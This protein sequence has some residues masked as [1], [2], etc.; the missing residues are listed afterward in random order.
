MPIRRRHPILLAT[1][2]SLMLAWMLILGW[3]AL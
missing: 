3:M 2:A 1:T